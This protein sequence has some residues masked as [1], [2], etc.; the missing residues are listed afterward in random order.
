M[1]ERK[2][3]LFEE[4]PTV[5]LLQLSYLQILNFLEKI[6]ETELNILEGTGFG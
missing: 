1:I 3:E 5:Q 6:I 4:D 2:I